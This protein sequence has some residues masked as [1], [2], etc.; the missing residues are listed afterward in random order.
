[1]IIKIILIQHQLHKDSKQML[2]NILNSFQTKD[3]QNIFYIVNFKFL[4]RKK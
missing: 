1:M 4:N 3:N 2:N